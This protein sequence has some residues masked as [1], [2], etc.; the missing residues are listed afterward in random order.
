VIFTQI[1]VNPDGQGESALIAAVIPEIQVHRPAAM[2]I[3]KQRGDLYTNS[4]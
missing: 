3:R 2:A 1:Q 4:S